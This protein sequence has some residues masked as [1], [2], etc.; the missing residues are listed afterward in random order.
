MNT[1]LLLWNLFL[2]AETEKKEKNPTKMYQWLSIT[3]DAE[4]WARLTHI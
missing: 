1:I 4:G 2:G 3:S